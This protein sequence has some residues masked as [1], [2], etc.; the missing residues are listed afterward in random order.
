MSKLI[1]LDGTMNEFAYGQALLFYKDDI[2]EVEKRKNI[3]LI[4]E[5]DGATCHTSKANKFLLNKFF[6]ED[7]WIQN[8]PNSPD[9]AYPIEDIWGIIKPRV[10]RR[11]PK[12]I[13]E[14]KQYLL[15]EWGSVPEEMVKNLCKGYL[16]KIKKIIELSGDRIEPEHRRQKKIS[17]VYDWEKP[18]EIQKQ[19]IVYNDKNLLFKKQTE[20]RLLKKQIKQVKEKFSKKMEIVNK[21][22]KKTKF[23]KRDLKNLSLGR[24]INIIRE[25][26]KAKDEKRKS[27]E[28]KNNSIQDIE[29]KIKK[30][31]KM[32]A[33][34]YL[35]YKNG[36]DEEDENSLS[37]KE[38]IEEKIDN[39]EQLIKENKEI[40]YKKIKF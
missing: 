23:K 13:E 33:F 40:K 34:E 19:R 24:G 1:F 10:K 28:E 36:E 38:E 30:I 7:G 2:E 12:S 15:E 20:I 18:E 4:F 25:N 16:D 3:K 31:S 21:N 8:P 27:I 5:Q 11:E 39:L 26:Q 29:E 37:T 17:I 6:T 9:L 22:I 14:L 32:N 35:R